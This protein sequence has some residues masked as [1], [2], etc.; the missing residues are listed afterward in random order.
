[1]RMPMRQSKTSQMYETMDWAKT[2]NEEKASPYNK[3]LDPSA[4]VAMGQSCGGLQAMET[5][6]TMAFSAKRTFY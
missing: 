5:P 6:G 3:K 4:I 1:M 2:Q